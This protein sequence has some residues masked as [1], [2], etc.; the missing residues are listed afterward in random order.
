MND[1]VK[2]LINRFCIAGCFVLVV[3]VLLVG[4]LELLVKD[5]SLLDEVPKAT[6]NKTIT[7]EVVYAND[8]GL[9][10]YDFVIHRITINNQSFLVNSK[11]GIIRE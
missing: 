4:M 1:L 6:V 9:E 7:N 3:G 2:Y 8:T 10:P 5:F 11:G